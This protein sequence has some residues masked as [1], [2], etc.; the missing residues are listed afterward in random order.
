[1]VVR[2]HRPRLGLTKTKQIRKSTAP[3]LTLRGGN[4]LG[5]TC[6]HREW[7]ISG[8]RDTG[9][10]CAC[11]ARVHK[12]ALTYPRA[13][14][15][16]VKKTQK[17]LA[18]TVLV[19]FERII[20]GYGVRGIGGE[21][22][23]LYRYPNGSVVWLGGM[24]N[25]DKVLSSE[26]DAIYVNQAEQVTLDD[27]E[28]L[29]GCCSGRAAV[30]PHPMLF[31]DCNPGGSK[32]WI[33]ERAK[34]GALQL[35][36]TTHR[37]NPTIYDKD[38]NVTES[39]KVRL[40]T[41]DALTGIRRKRLRNGEWVTAE[42]AVYDM[43]DAAVHVKE[44]KRDEFRRWFLA[45]DA[46]Y[47]N[48][49]VI[50]DVGADADNRWHVFQEFYKSGVLQ[51]AVV[52][53]AVQWNLAHLREVAAVDAASPAFIAEL[54]NSGINAVGGKGKVNDG[55]HAVQDR[56]GVRGDGLPRLTVDP[57]CENLINELESYVWQPGKD[58]PVKEF[59]HGCDALR[60]LADVLGEV[61]GAFSST[62]GISVGAHNEW[63]EGQRIEF[64][65]L[66]LEDM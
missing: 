19:T 26:R 15:A 20:R 16:I 9:K 45:L 43:F 22:P 7:I 12:L 1:M 18:G 35:F 34:A 37:D 48:P 46:G 24:D 32:H 2:L 57:G 14:L 38:G 36:P 51:S 59:D 28:M 27:W 21:S 10:T 63:T 33:R 23:H 4:G 11:C 49:W 6:T 58:V 56:F 5:Y 60:Y 55:I 42:G 25:P 44:R 47:V 8:P 53:Q 65:D 52:N 66:K 31:G 62:E 17:S 40:V 29:L 64:E 13:N 30:V 39:G 50:L 41:L 54:V 3:E 61:S